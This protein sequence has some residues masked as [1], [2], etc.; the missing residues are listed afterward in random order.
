MDRGDW[1]DAVLADAISPETWCQWVYTWDA[2][3]GTHE[4]R[5]RATDTTGETQTA[6]VNPPAPGGATGYHARVVLVEDS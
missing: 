6:D 4:F 3:P 5:V 2:T 1:E